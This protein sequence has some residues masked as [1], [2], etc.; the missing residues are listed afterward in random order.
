MWNNPSV[1]LCRSQTPSMLTLTPG[2]G[3]ESGGTKV[4]VT[5]ENLSAGSAV[6]VYFGTQTCEL[7]RWAW[8]T[9][10]F[11]LKANMK[12]G[13]Y[14]VKWH[15]CWIQMKLCT[16]LFGPDS[17]GSDETHNTA[18]SIFIGIYLRFMLPLVFG[19]RRSVLLEHYVE[20]PLISLPSL[21]GPKSGSEQ[22]VSL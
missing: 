17:S 14:C 8:N 18:P 4:T 20:R 16:R 3:P 11:I 9:H 22:I 19:V 7:F 10:Q 6:N 12:K 5:G 13:D 21:I 15:L 2:R 1:Q